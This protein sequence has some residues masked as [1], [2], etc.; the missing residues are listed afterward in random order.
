MAED[1][2]RTSKED[3]D[4]QARR[5]SREDGDR[6]ASNGLAKEEEGEE[7]GLKKRPSNTPFVTVIR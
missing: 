2:Q 4:R 6:Q 3:G 5:T 7:A 1:R